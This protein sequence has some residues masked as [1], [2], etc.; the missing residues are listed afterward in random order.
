[1]RGRWVTAAL[2]GIAVLTPAGAG[3]STPMG[4][5]SVVVSGE[6]VGT[7]TAVARNLVRADFNDITAPDGTPLS[8][9]AVSGT[10]DVVA[11][12]ARRDGGEVLVATARPGQ[13]RAVRL[14]VFDP[15]PTD[16]RAIIRI[17]N[18]TS[19]DQLNFG[20][21]NFT[22]GADF[23]LDAVSSEPGSTDDG[24]NLVQRGLYEDPD[25]YK[26]QLDGRHPSCRLKGAT[27]GGATE[28]EVR[29]TVEVDSSNWYRARC[30]RTGVDLDVVVTRYDADGT[31]QR[32]TTR[33]T[34]EAVIDVQ[35]DTAAV[36]LS[37]GG[38]LNVDGTVN[39]DSDQFNG[40][41]D[42]AVVRLR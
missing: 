38:K 21:R 14:P 11:E 31:R 13:G 24:D 42:N 40:L 3:A 39:V 9:I 16:P 36:P 41:V 27:T 5:G 33:V 22:F 30:V 4:T 18:A 12:V 26:L 15:S 8:T 29:S 2:V 34:S 37:I 19:E 23:L 7:Q 32:T 6:G 1:M 17:T 20:T 25:Q 10:A 35:M 28:V